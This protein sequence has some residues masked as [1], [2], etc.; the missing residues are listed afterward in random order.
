VRVRKKE[1]NSSVVT[2]GC[3]DSGSKVSFCA[4]DLMHQLGAKGKRVKLSI[5]MHTYEVG[6]L[7]ILDLH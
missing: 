1:G 6:D 2:Y 3:I 4:E 5:V 7:E